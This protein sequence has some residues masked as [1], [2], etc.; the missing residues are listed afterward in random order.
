MLKCTRS[1][2]DTNIVYIITVLARQRLETDGSLSD[3]TNLDVDDI[4]SLSLCLTTTYFS[5]QGVTYQQIHGT[6]MGSPVAAVVTNLV[7]VLFWYWQV[8]SFSSSETWCTFQRETRK[9]TGSNTT[10]LIEASCEVKYYVRNAVVKRG[11]TNRL[12]L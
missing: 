9:L 6:A 7:R 12:M 2:A 11:L 3:C 4:F 8:L 1:I 10:L 5:F